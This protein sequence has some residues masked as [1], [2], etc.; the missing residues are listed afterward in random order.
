MRTDSLRPLLPTTLALALIPFAGCGDDSSNDGGADGSAGSTDTT[1]T[2]G[3][4]GGDGSTGGGE[5]PARVAVTADWL[6]G[7]LTILDYEA[8][9]TATTRD[10]ALYDEIDLGMY[11]PG[12]LEVELTSDGRTAVVASAPGFFDG[13]VGALINAGEVPAGGSLL[14]V[15]LETGDVQE[16]PT[17]HTPMGIAISADDSTAYVANFGEAAE[18]GS[19]MTVVDLGTASVTAEFEVGGGPEQIDLSPDGTVGMVN[20][21]GDGG[22]KTFSTSDPENTLS[23]NLEV[24]GD[25]SW[26]LFLDQT[27]TKGFVTN[28]MGPPGYSVLDLSTPSMPAVLEQQM[29]LGF[30][31]AGAVMPG[32]DTVYMIGAEDIL[33]FYEIDAGAEPAV[34]NYDLNITAMAFPLGVVLDPTDNLAFFAAPGANTLVRVELATQDVVQIP[35][36]MDAAGPTYFALQPAL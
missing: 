17:L 9:K 33:H 28:S 10:E 30:P 34:V 6:N 16:V 15:D 3:D 29:S 23:D 25:P 1:S 7:S 18:S 35:W 19:S 26:V 22:I 14:I 20:L 13:F 4:T 36:N 5:F 11:A 27:P 8:L 2:G 31:Y 24:S 12:P 21:A 32:T